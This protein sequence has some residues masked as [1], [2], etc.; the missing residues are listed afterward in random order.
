[1]P[2]D[3]PKQEEVRRLTEAMTAEFEMKILA[4]PEQWFWMHRR[5]RHPGRRETD[6]ESAEQEA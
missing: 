3:R 5:W 2:E 4:H 1:M 6:K